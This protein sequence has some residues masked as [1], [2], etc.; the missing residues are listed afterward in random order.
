MA[1]HFVKLFID[2]CAHTNYCLS[3]QTFFQIL[4]DYVVFVSIVDKMWM[5]VYYRSDRVLY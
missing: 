3:F 1:I 5:C 2:N 4:I